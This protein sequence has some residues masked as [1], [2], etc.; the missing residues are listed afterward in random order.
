MAPAAHRI[1]SALAQVTFAE[2]RIEVWSSTTAAPVHGS[3]EIKDV[4]V[5][6]LVSPVRWRETV[7]GLAARHGTAF[8]DLGP[9][10]VVGA[11]AKRIV[12]G[13]DVGFVADLLPASAPAS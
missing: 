10:G 13:A 11:L 2:P 4:L 1:E 12:K 6:Q 5:A 3:D 9:G 7:E 8:A